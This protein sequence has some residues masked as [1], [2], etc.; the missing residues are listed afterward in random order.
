MGQGQLGGQPGDGRFQQP[1]GPQ[2]IPV[3]DEQGECI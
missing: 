2:N 1:Q 3:M